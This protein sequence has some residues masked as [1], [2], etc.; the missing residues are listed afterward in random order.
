[1]ETN[2][3]GLFIKLDNENWAIIPRATVT[4]TVTLEQIELLLVSRG[5]VRQA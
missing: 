2:A 5:A 4:G 1:M 3:D